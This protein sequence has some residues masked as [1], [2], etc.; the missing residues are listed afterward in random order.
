MLE[1][2]F[3]TLQLL[4]NRTAYLWCQSEIAN[5]NPFSMFLLGESI[6]WDMTASLIQRN[7]LNLETISIVP[8]QGNIISWLKAQLCPIECSQW[9]SMPVWPFIQYAHKHIL[10]FLTN[11]LL[12]Q[13]STVHLMRAG[14]M[15]LRTECFK[16]K[17]RALLRFGEH[18]G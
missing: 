18:L 1:L 14:V 6:F 11:S 7:S 13:I 5:N 4:V 8:S 10:L 3:A 15:F 17:C 2:T 12:L 16:V 9:V